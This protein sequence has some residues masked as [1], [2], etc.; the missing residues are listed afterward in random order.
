MDKMH[1]DFKSRRTHHFS[2]KALLGNGSTF[3]VGQFW[4]TLLQVGVALLL[5]F[6]LIWT[7]ARGRSFAIPCI[8]LVNVLHALNDAPNG[9]ETLTV[10][11][12]IVGCVDDYEINQQG[13]VQIRTKV[14]GER[15]GRS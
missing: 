3:N 8:Q 1:S 12:S 13:D 10:E 9:R 7:V 11:K 4:E 2:S 14:R 5:D 15:M 6:T